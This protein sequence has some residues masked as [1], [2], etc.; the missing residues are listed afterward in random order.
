M[1]RSGAKRTAKQGPSIGSEETRRTLV[2]ATIE[3]LREEGFSGTSA[4][5]IA[6]RAGCNQ[7]LVFY[8]FGTVTN[9]LLA[10]LDEVSSTRHAHYQA[11]VDRATGLGELVDAAEGV[12]EEDLDAGHIA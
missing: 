7:G 10:A 12:F 3:A 5:E 6:R 4:R 2:T 9:L 1:A 11:A 8:H